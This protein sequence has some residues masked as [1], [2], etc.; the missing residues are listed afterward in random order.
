MNVAIITG[1]SSGLGREFARQLNE[2]IV[3]KELKGIHE[4]WLI[5]RRKDRMEELAAKVK[6]KCKI[7][8]MDVA[9]HKKMDEFAEILQIANPQIKMLV[10]CAGF[11]LLGKFRQ[12][13]INDQLSMVDVNCKAL[14]KMTYLCIP[15]MSRNSRII[16]LASSA[17]FLP[18]PNFAV[19]AATKSYVLSFS[20]AL[21]EELRRDG[22]VVTAVCPGPIRTEFFSIAEKFGSNFAV[23]QLT[24]VEASGVVRSALKAAYKKKSISVYSPFIKLFHL[25][26]KILPTKLLL[27]IVRLF[28]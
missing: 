10:N 12:L 1:A 11:G 23:K 8:V 27:I 6:I 15:Y 2:K 9:D 28:K 19:Y 7:I 16:Q 24:M 3:K 14:T 22:I 18:Q 25:G 13:E 4:L 21:S 20:Y 26:A 5:A 17:A